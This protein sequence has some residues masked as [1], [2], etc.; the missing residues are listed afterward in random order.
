MKNRS[1]RDILKH[2]ADVFL[3]DSINNF[4]LIN[5]VGDK[6]KTFYINNWSIVHLISG[7]ILGYIVDKYLLID[8]SNLIIENY[9]FKMF[10]LHTIW[11]LWQIFSNISNPF[12]ITGDSNIVDIIIDTILFMIGAYIYKELM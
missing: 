4:L 10:I 3:P 11:E 8:N 12:S 1:L 6:S 2:S 7:F 9:Y 5:I